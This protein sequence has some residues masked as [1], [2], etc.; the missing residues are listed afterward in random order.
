[1]SV[2]TKKVSELPVL[3][4]ATEQANLLVECDGEVKRLNV[5]ELA[6][7]ETIG[8]ISAALDGIIA[9]QNELIGGD[10]V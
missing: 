1:M 7:A 8:D 10:G 5:K 4:Q 2:P 6:D 3:D 9:M